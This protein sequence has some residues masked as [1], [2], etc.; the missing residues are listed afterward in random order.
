MAD[1]LKI[2]TAEQLYEIYRLYLISKGVGLT[3]FNAGGKTNT[4]IES[5]SDV[6]SSISMDF[7]EGIIKAIPI[8]LY[9]G[10]GFGRTDAVASNG[11]I[12]PYRNPVLWIKYIGL[13]TSA[14]LTSTATTISSVVTGAGAD[15]FSFNYTTYPT[16]QDIVT[17]IGNETNWEATLVG[18]GSID[19]IDLYQYTSKEVIGA[20]NYLNITGL[21]IMLAI[22]I[23]IS[24]PTGFSVTI[25]ELPILTTANGTIPAGESGV[26]IAA[27]ASVA[28]STGNIIANAID[29]ANGKG[30][31]NSS[32]DGIQYAIND[33][34]F[35]GGSAQETSNE[36]QVRFSETVNNLNAG[37]ANGII[38]ELKKITGV[39]SV[40]IRS[41]Y[42]FKGTVTIVVD[43][44]TFT[45]SSTLLTSVEK[46][47]YGDPNDIINFPGKNAEGISY[48]IVAPDV[49][50]VNI[51]ITVTKLATVNVE[52]SV[53][54]TAVQSAIEQYI[55]TLKLGEDVILTAIS[56]VARSANSA[57]YDVAITSPLTNITIAAGSF[58]KT[59][60]GTS[61]LVTVT[62]VNI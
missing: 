42:P 44:G 33:S 59:G 54:Q 8:A 19:S 21:D 24:V 58:A 10:L 38:S 29:T 11:F 34:A 7:K 39:R 22:D 32:I 20:T 53:I 36:R 47:L 40:G 15:N 6:I 18:D 35:S 9:E 62:M 12:R 25:D 43:D 52:N 5:N 30:V 45:I 37:T 17:A 41:S 49:A 26:Q 48:L 13:G 28:G 16:I 56:Q 23:A 2:Y 4:L 31:I 46:R 50:D 61:G 3:D 57:V 14:Q 55:N 51:S 60:A 1:I 27:E